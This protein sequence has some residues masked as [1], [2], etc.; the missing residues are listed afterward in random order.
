MKAILLSL[1]ILSIGISSGSARTWKSADG[2][3]SF[4]GELRNYNPETGFVTVVLSNG[5]SIEFQQD[6]LS[7]EDLEFLESAETTSAPSPAA[8]PNPDTKVGKLISRAKLH[9]IEE[10]KFEKAEL[11]KSPEYYILY[12]SASW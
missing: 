7:K 2:S 10:D 11:D 1:A 9:K 3:K 8:G 4:D 5:R 12:Y 6:L